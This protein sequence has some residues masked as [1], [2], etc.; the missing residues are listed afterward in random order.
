MHEYAF[1]I[2]LNTTARTYAD[3]EAQA[4]E[5]LLALDREFQL[6]YRAGQA[7]GEVWL[8]DASMAHEA[9]AAVLIEPAPAVPPAE[10]PLYRAGCDGY[11][12]VFDITRAAGWTRYSDDSG[13]NHTDVSPDGQLAVE[14]GPEADAPATAPLWRIHFRNPDPYQRS[15]NTWAAYFEGGTPAEAIAA[16]LAAVT[17]ANPRTANTTGIRA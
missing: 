6:E 17:T 16:F 2:Q 9:A 7:G 3:T 4:R 8:A 14:F 5:H 10:L 13:D 1:D 15:D 12:P 11:D